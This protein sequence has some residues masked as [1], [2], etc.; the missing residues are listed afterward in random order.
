MADT[1]GNLKDSSSDESR[2]LTDEEEYRRR[3]EALDERIQQLYDERHHIIQSHR[4]R[5]GGIHERAAHQEEER[6]KHVDKGYETRLHETF[7]EA[8]QEIYQD[9]DKLYGEIRKNMKTLDERIQTL[10]KE[11]TQLTRDWE[12]RV[13]STAASKQ[14][15]TKESVRGCSY[16]VRQ[17]G[18]ML[19]NDYT[20]IRENLPF[21]VRN[22]IPDKLIDRLF[23]KG[24][25][26]DDDIETINKQKENG[27][28][29]VVRK[30]LMILLHCGEH[31]YRLFIESLQEEGF[32]RAVEILENV[33]QTH[34]GSVRG[35]VPP[36]EYNRI[37]LNFTYLIN[38]ITNPWTLIIRL[39][40]KKVID[41]EEFEQI[42]STEEKQTA[43]RKLLHILLFCGPGTLYKLMQSLREEDCTDIADQLE[44]GSAPRQESKS[45]KQAV[46][47]NPKLLK[48]EETA[49]I[50]LEGI[51][52][53]S[54]PETRA[55]SEGCKVLNNNFILGVIGATGDGKS[56]LSSMVAANF[57]ENHCDFAPLVIKLGDIDEISF[58]EKR[59][60]LLIMDDILGRFDRSNVNISQFQVNFDNLYLNI[61][62][63]R[64]A[65]IYVIRDYIYNDCKHVRNIYDI[66]SNEYCI[67]LHRESI[68][69]NRQ[70]REKIIKYHSK[71]LQDSDIQTINEI[72]ATTFGFPSIAKLLSKL[73]STCK[74]VE[75]FAFTSLND[76]LLSNFEMFWKE[77]KDKY[78]CFLL[79]FSLRPLT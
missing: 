56:V 45:P 1:R 58:S 43:T 17:G 20:N 33:P 55:Y 54:Y 50:M 41:D 66:F 32:T 6:R 30:M 23:S 53:D 15:L 78:A 69:L 42:E 9:V 29:A 7:R 8:E 76:F 51:K 22:L 25:F 5:K 19:E 52:E 49:K 21:L 68:C 61:K 70:E 71:Q 31:A 59:N 60:L 77:Y 63:R 40:N 2:R 37:Q 4:Y 18:P 46:F 13:D 48:A 28:S 38:T 39:Y 44:S 35:K 74:Q 73:L 47:K 75:I 72:C 64:A 65:L 11:K 36:I 3:I 34:E 79:A 12:K 14:D 57:L 67:F 62:R 24:V 26:N 27:R 10:E 16:L